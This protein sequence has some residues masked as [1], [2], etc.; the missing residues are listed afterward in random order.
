MKQVEVSCPSCQKHIEIAVSASGAYNLGNGACWN[1]GKKYKVL[2]PVNQDGIRET[3]FAAVAAG[4]A[5]AGQKRGMSMPTDLLKLQTPFDHKLGGQWF[6]S[7]VPPPLRALTGTSI[8]GHNNGTGKGGNSVPE[9]F[10]GKYNLAPGVENGI[11]EVAHDQTCVRVSYYF[12]VP[13]VEVVAEA[14]RQSAGLI[15]AGIRASV[16]ST[17]VTIETERKRLIASTS[18]DLISEKEI[19]A[20]MAMW[21]GKSEHKFDGILPAPTAASGVVAFSLGTQLRSD[22]EPFIHPRLQK[23]GM[24]Q[25]VKHLALY[26]P[27]GETNEDVEQEFLAALRGWGITAFEVAG[28]PFDPAAVVSATM[29]GVPYGPGGHSLDLLHTRLKTAREHFVGCFAQIARAFVPPAKPV[30]EGDAA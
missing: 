24:L 23:Q 26:V 20:G 15:A 29:D 13:E 22:G 4:T 14:I 5:G 27:E 11:A 19:E 2:F 9:K 16:E 17:I 6:R 25:A 18:S 7:A 3:L 1:C 30:E 21:E 12:V 8:R 10:A 28:H